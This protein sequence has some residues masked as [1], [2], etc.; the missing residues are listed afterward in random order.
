MWY[1]FDVQKFG[2]QMLPPILRGDVMRALLKVFL[3]PLVWLFR[4]LR[5]L[6]GETK[7]RLS[8]NGQVLSLTEALRRAYRLK[9]GDIYI[10]DS[11]YKQ[12]Y[13]YKKD[14][15]QHPIYLHRESV[16][17][18]KT[19][20]YYEDASRV[21]PDYYIYIPD[22]LQSESEG[23][24]RLIEQYKPAGRKYKIIYYPYE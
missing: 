21:E 5:M 17:N 10:V 4:Q 12:P 6:Q 2:W 1:N 14:E 18:S 23:I 11:E 22:F 13:L 7:E 19:Q 3:L 15:G 16:S 8:S 9:E 20:L 24:L